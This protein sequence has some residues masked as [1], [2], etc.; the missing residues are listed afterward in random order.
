MK[1]YAQFWFDTED[2]ITPE[3]DDALYGLLVML[4]EKNVPVTFKLVAEKAR[5]LERRKRYDIIDLLQNCENFSI[6]YHTEFHSVHPTIAEY[7]ETMGF[8]EGRDAFF[9]RENPGRLDVERITGKKC[10][11]YGQ[12]GNTWAPQ[13]FPALTKMGIPVYMDSHNVIDGG[14]KPYWFGGLL[15]YLDVPF[16][17]MWLSSDYEKNMRDAKEEFKSF[18]EEHKNDEVAFLNIFYHPCEFSCTEFYD[19]NFARGKNPAREDWKPAP[20]RSIEQMLKLIAQIGNFIDFLCEQNVNIISP[21]TLLKLE[22]SKKGEIPQNIVNVW[23]EN[24]AKC[25][26]DCLVKDGYNI[27]AVEGLSLVAR[28]MLNKPLTASFAYGPENGVKSEIS[29]N[30]NSTATHNLAKTVFEFFETN[31]DNKLAVL[32]DTFNVDNMQLSPLDAVVILSQ[33][34]LNKDYAPTK[35]RLCPSERVTTDDDWSG[36]IIHREDFRVPNILDIA[37]RQMWTFKP[38]VF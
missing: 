12:P 33:A 24:A 22:A 17:R 28:K 5:M 11:C 19:L 9:V 37:K 31:K 35:S 30:L 23:A 2:F 38:A 34:L 20:L 21:S 4:K 1:I 10:V 36:W 6:G 14:Q 15:N 25:N 27:S 13:A 8:T 16:Y 26:V 32:P 7:C 18:A 3:A 29:E